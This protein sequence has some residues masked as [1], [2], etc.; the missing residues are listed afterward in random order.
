MSKPFEIG[1]EPPPLASKNQRKL[2]PKKFTKG[3]F[4]DINSFLDFAASNLE[5]SDLVVWL[6][7]WRDTGRDGCARPSTQYLA[8]RAGC[9]RE[10]VSRAIASLT[11]KGLLSIIHRGGLNRG[12]SVYRIRPPNM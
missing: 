9:S 1:A 4:N 12:P 3:R 5:R 6:L 10:T 8:M 11:S 7:L 2:T